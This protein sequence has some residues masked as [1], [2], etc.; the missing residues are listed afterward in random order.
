MAMNLRKIN[1]LIAT[2]VLEWEAEEIEGS[3]YLSGYILYKRKEPSHIPEYEFSP[4][5]DMDQAL[6]AA[7][8]WVNKQATI[9]NNF[10]IL[11]DGDQY[12]AWVGDVNYKGC[13]KTAALA[14]CLALLR[15]EG[16]NIE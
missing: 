8:T 9:K 12:H 2:E 3:P 5:T 1:H 14:L 15:A 13:A 10:T 16:V 4:T 7:E 11:Y 6:L